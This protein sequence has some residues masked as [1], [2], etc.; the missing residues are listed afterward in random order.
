LDP[1][2]A[3]RET[4]VIEV[5]GPDRVD[6]LQ[7]QLTQDVRGMMSGEVR[8]SAALT[9]KGKILYVAR[10]LSLGDRFLLLLPSSSRASVLEHLKKYAAFQ[11]VALED[12]SPELLRVALYGSMPEPPPA[13]EGIALPGEG[14]L[15]GELLVPAAGREAALAELEGK[16]SRPLDSE[17]A[18]RLRVESG[19]PRFGQDFDDSHVPDEVGLSAAI[20]TTKGCYVGQEIVARMRTYGRVNRRLVGF[21]FPDG[22]VPA[23]SVLQRPDGEPGKIEWGRVTSAVE[24]RRFGPIGLGFAYHEVPEGGR[25]VTTESPQRSA[26]IAALPFR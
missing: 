17:E 1:A 16:G 8:P 21:R 15:A 11:K 10:V 7:G 5:S 12:R 6:F 24:S 4:A 22:I 3:V 9:P 23:G 19:R 14:E 18:E 26:V 13:T 20:S 2:H 25:L